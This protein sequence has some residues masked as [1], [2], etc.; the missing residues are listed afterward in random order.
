[1]FRLIPIIALLALLFFGVSWLRKLPPGKKRQAVTRLLIG[2]LIVTLI[3]LAITGRIHWLGALLGALI[4]LGKTL[5]GLAAQFLPFLQRHKAAQ[6]P[7]PDSPN[8]NITLEEALLTL[9]LKDGYQAGTLSPDDV[10]L[11]HKRLIQK[12]HPDRGGNDYLAARIN[13]AKTCVLKALS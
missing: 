7:P 11:A 9:G 5:L 6:T 2:A 3:F 10:E 8:S 1:M 4:P 13:A 12:L